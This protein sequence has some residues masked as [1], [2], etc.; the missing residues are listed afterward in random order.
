MLGVDVEREEGDARSS[1]HPSSRK[2][3]WRT[4]PELGR[5]SRAHQRASP[6]PFCFAH[7]QVVAA[8]LGSLCPRQNPTLLPQPMAKESKRGG[9][10]EEEDVGDVMRM[11]TWIL[12]CDC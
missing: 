9:E 12:L 3:P 5:G 1:G 11:R 10:G 4:P 7:K 2:V 6:V 8:V